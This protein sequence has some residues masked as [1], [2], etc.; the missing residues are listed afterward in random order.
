MK[1]SQDLLAFF[2]ED[3]FRLVLLHGA[4]QLHAA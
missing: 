3:W 4:W 2:M 1:V